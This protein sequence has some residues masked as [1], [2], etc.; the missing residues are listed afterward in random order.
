MRNPFRKPCICPIRMKD[1]LIGL[2][3]QR[4]GESTEAVIQVDGK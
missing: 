1:Y 3:C 2:R 4:H